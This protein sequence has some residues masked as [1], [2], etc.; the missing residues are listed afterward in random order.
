M[1]VYIW[2][3]VWTI[4]NLNLTDF[5]THFYKCEIHT[6]SGELEYNNVKIKIVL[7]LDEVLILI[8][9]LVG[10]RWA[11]IFRGGKIDTRTC[12]MQMDRPN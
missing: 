12:F 7:S 8:K 2:Q 10:D 3:P 5:S 9:I 11:F 1:S 6:L 4:G